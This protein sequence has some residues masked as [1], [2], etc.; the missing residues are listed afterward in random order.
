MRIESKEACTVD[1]SQLKSKDTKLVNVGI[2]SAHA[3]VVNGNFIFYTPRAIRQGCLSL[4]EFYKPLQRKHFDK[5][6]GYIY[7]ATY[8]AKADSNY[9][10]ALEAADTFEELGAIAKEYYY[11]DEYKQNS[12]GFGALLAKAKLYDQDKIQELKSNKRGH[13]SIAGESVN[14]VCSVCFDIIG[15]DTC[16]HVPGGTYNGDVCFAIADNLKLDHIS[17][18]E[19]PASWKTNTLIIADSKIISKIELTEE[20]NTMKYTLEQ[21]KELLADRVGLLTLLGL[22]A[23]STQYEKE[24]EEAT[25]SSFLFP[26]EKGLHLNTKLGVLVAKKV[27]ELLVEEETTQVVTASIDKEY[28]KVLGETSIEDALVALEEEVKAVVEPE[29]EPEEPVKTEE[30]EGE[31]EGTDLVVDKEAEGEQNVPLQ[32]QDANQVILQIV[33]QL[34]AAF[35]SKLEAFKTELKAENTNTANQIYED[36][37]DA[38]Q[39]DLVLSQTVEKQLTESLKDSLLTQIVLLKK[40]D[41]ESEYFSKL[42]ERTVQELRLTLEDLQ[43]FAEQNTPVVVLDVKDSQNTV[44]EQPKQ[45][46]KTAA[47]AEADDGDKNVTLQI[48]DADQI[49]SGIVEGI[50]PRCLERNEYAALY[51]DT[52]NKHG[53]DTAR[54]LHV[55]LKQQY[56]I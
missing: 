16:K 21:I 30:G 47:V 11:S 44:I 36:R 27:A 33:D 10:T 5:T 53:L 22:E 15:G 51:K 42:K 45:I 23:Y 2:E 48:E 1:T 41:V 54:R 25:T 32:I 29:K 49:I 31:G 20:G 52:A 6:L 38:L 46:S 43:A 7:D 12:E 17:F 9:I 24:A 26:K 39:Q 8:V 14:A 13:V 34:S 35:D 3:G 19:T 28:E 55:A 56:K 4:K 50:G 37:I 40:V 18:E